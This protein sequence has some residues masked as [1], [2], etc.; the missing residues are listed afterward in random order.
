MPA[1]GDGYPDIYAAGDVV[2]TADSS[3]DTPMAR[4]LDVRT[5][6]QLWTRHVDLATDSAKVTA[7]TGAVYLVDE[8]KNDTST[9]RA[10]DP[11]SG[12]TLWTYPMPLNNFVW[13]VAAT[14]P[15][16]CVAGGDAV[17][18]FTTGSGK[19]SWRTAVEGLYVTAAAGLVLVESSER[20]ANVLTAL[21]A[22]TGRVRWTH[23][24][25][26][27]PQY[28]TIGDGFV[29]THDAYGGLYALHS[30][31][32]RTA[33]NKTM[34]TRSSVRRTGSGMLFVDDADG[35]IRALSATTGAEVWSRRMGQGAANPY[36]ESTA[37]GL[38][39]DTLFVGTTDS[40]VY[41]LNTADG[42]VL[43]T[44][45]ADAMNSS[46]SS[47]D[48]GWGAL[49][50]DGLVVLSTQDGYIEAV[51]PPGGSQGATPNGAPDAA[52]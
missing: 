30:D 19:V 52:A 3:T 5:G 33:W 4:A 7:G 27:Q 1:G 34:D 22:T 9:L 39:G 10:V 2:L 43:W 15:T 46:D 11:A 23:K 28:T 17:T 35:R 45:G 38:S 49:A 51:G 48:P 24:L 41:A 13:G 50:V 18:G 37:I 29:F 44:Y 21:S 36:G 20:D 12:A 31:T 25:A 14:G 26:D 47:S 40:V 42:S 16:V 6:R 8:R 32:G